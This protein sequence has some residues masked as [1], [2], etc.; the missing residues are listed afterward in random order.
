[1]SFKKTKFKAIKEAIPRKVA[2]FIYR[3]FLNKRKVARHLFDTRYIS[4]FTEYWGVW[5]D[6]MIPNTYSHYGDTAFETV[7]DGLTE[8]ME[9]ESG[10]KL[11]PSYAYARIY[12]KE[13]YFIGILI[14]IL[15]KF[16]LP[17]T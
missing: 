10:Y 12:K 16:L 15:V 3:Y 9:K 17:C 4:Q 1:M 11:N 8:R 14:E 7:L 13:T 5:N 2:D 6:S